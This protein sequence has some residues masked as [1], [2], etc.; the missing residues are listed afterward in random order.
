MSCVVILLSLPNLLLQAPLSSDVEMKRQR[1]D[2][3]EDVPEQVGAPWRPCLL[4]PCESP[5]PSR[6]GFSL[7]KPVRRFPMRQPLLVPATLPVA[8]CS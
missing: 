5:S 1:E 3:V 7:I 4:P 8:R 6:S 2:D